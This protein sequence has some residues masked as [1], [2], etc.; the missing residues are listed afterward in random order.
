MEKNVKKN[1]LNKYWIKLTYWST[2]IS[3]QVNILSYLFQ[4][5]WVTNKLQINFTCFFKSMLPV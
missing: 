2:N 5:F 4:M 1:V 3:C